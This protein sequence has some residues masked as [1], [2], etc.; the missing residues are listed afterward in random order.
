M[1][2]WKRERKVSTTVAISFTGM[3]VTICTSEDRS[4]SFFEISGNYMYKLSAKATQV[5]A[6]LGVEMP[7]AL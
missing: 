6:K 1:Q 3:V 5:N 4:L 7:T 2:S